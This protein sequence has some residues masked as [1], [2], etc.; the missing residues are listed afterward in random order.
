[1]SQQFNAVFH[2]GAFQPEEPVVAFVEGQ[3]VRLTVESTEPA[4]SENLLALCVEVY[5]GLSGDEV[6]EVEQ[7]ATDRSTF[8]TGG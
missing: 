1:M 2:N 5:S 4:P 3:Q 6:D 8:F 7:I